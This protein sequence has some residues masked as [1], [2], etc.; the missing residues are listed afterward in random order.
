MTRTAFGFFLSATFLVGCIA[1]PQVEAIPAES[2]C[3]V[4]SDSDVEQI[5]AAAISVKSRGPDFL[6]ST[7]SVTA[8]T[9]VYF[10]YVRLLPEL[11]ESFEDRNRQPRAI[12]VDLDLPLNGTTTVLRE[13]EYPSPA[14]PWDYPSWQNFL[15]RTFDARHVHRVTVP[16]TD[17][18]GE[19]AAVYIEHTCGSF[20]SEGRLYLVA[21]VDGVWFE[22]F[23]EQQWIS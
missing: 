1:P 10:E 19:I 17:C 21:R 14:E 12:D 5:W 18:A 11:R 13:D 7:P 2:F 3:Y 16:A 4:L 22:I 6:V 20:C 23:N 9:G 8:D 15:T